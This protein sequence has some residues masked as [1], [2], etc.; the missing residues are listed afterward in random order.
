ME[1]GGVW[2]FLVLFLLSGFV[3]VF[4]GGV[5]FCLCGLVWVEVL[6]LVGWFGVFLLTIFLFVLRVQFEVI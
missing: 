2:G 3:G 1:F 4:A 5:V 6:D